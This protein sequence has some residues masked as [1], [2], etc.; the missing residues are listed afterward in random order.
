MQQKILAEIEATLTRIP[1]TEL[2]RS[3]TYVNVGTLY[4]MEGVATV[5]Q[6][7]YQFNTDSCW[8]T[9]SD[10]LVEA[11]V[12]E[13]RISADDNDFPGRLSQSGWHLT[14]RYDDG[15]A[16]GAM[17]ERLSRVVEPSIPAAARPQV[18]RLPTRRERTAFIIAAAL[19][20]A[21]TLSLLCRHDLA[22]A[23]VA[24][25]LAARS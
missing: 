3:G 23:V 24:L 13:G 12:D 5:L 15:N 17:L 20:A 19:S 2:V 9:F 8:L 18:R 22:H 14:L 6:V 16:L 10:V 25:L 1:G 11:A 4:L 21:L 7:T